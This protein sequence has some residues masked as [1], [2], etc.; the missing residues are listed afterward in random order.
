MIG[1]AWPTSWPSRFLVWFLW[2]LVRSLLAFQGHWS[3]RVDFLALTLFG[4]VCPGVGSFAARVSVELV[5]L[6]RLFGPLCSGNRPQQ[7]DGLPSGSL[8]VLFFQGRA[9]H[10]IPK[11]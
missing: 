4:L 5:W 7:R 11:K 8:D 9:P 6:D 1:S 2:T 3:G 10:G